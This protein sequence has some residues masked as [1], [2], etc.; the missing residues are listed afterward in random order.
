MWAYLCKLLTLIFNYYRR[1]SQVIVPRELTDVDP[2]SL[3]EEDMHGA[4]SSASNRTQKRRSEEARQ[5]KRKRTTEEVETE[6]EAARGEVERLRHSLNVTKDENADLLKSK[7]ELLG[8]LK[9]SED[10]I[11]KASVDIRM[12]QEHI[13]QQAGRIVELTRDR[14]QLEQTT[15]ELG[16]CQRRRQEMEALLTVRSAELRDAQQYLG[17]VDAVSYA[18]VKRMVE[19]MNSQIFQLAAQVVDGFS[20]EKTRSHP[21]PELVQACCKSVGESLGSE[22]FANVVSTSAH[23]DDSM[24]VQ[25]MIQAYLAQRIS[26]VIAAW[27]SNLRSSQSV[28]LSKIHENILKHGKPM[29]IG[30]IFLLSQTYLQRP[31]PFQHVG[32]HSLGVI[33]TKAEITMETAWSTSAVVSFEIYREFY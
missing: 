10:T 15:R 30:C 8:K 16:A 6:L 24:L 2:G 11:V 3:V 5:R 32:E 27:A 7:R 25:A 28:L 33:S 31:R 1:L 19:A 13:Q 23:A 20:F 26:N 29:R 17:K 4:S 12:L 18:D 21:V 14:D 9:A 22:Y